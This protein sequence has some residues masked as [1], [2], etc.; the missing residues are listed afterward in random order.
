MRYFLHAASNAHFF[1]RVGS[2]ANSGSVYKSKLYA[3]HIQHFFHRVTRGSRYIAHYRAF[4]IQQGIQ[5]RRLPRIRSSNNGNRNA[6]LN[7]ISQ[8][9]TIAKLNN[10]LQNFIQQIQQLRSIGKLNIFLRKIQFQFQQRRE[11]NQAFAQPVDLLRKSSAH[12]MHRLLVRCSTFRCYHISN[13]FCPTQIHS[14]VQIRTHGVLA[15][16]CHA[17]AI[18]LQQLQD[19]LL[20]VTR[21]VTSNFNHI[22]P[23]K[24]MRTLKQSHHHFIQDFLPIENASENRFAFFFGLKGLR[25]QFAHYNPSLTSANANYSD[26]A[27]SLRCRKRADRLFS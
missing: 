23:R 3:F 11:M 10:H 8:L 17:T 20:N 25:K 26:T 13:R 7:G 9:K 5:Q 1:Y 27:N 4:L 19:A 24:T 6:I 15:C 16:C 14:S 12:L 22:F 2:L 18:F 21:S